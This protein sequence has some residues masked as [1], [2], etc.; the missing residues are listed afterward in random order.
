MNASPFPETIQEIKKSK[1]INLGYN[2]Q[3]FFLSLSLEENS[4]IFNIQEKYSLYYY[5]KEL[6]LHD[7]VNLHKYFRFFDNLSEIFDD[8]IKNEL[9]IKEINDIKKI[10]VLSFKVV[11]NK[12]NY[13][14]NII[15][16]GKELDKVKDIDIIITNYKEMKKELDALKQKYGLNSNNNET[17]GNIFND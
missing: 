3:S 13:E 17:N 5:K 7:F 6:T 2:S 12:D 1:N 15:L 14:I 4:I 10:L 11:I 9:I 8:I 16:D